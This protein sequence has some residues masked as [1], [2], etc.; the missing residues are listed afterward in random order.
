[1]CPPPGAMDLYRTHVKG[2]KFVEYRYDASGTAAYL[3][4]FE[5]IDK[6]RPFIRCE[7]FRILAQAGADS[8]FALGEGHVEGHVELLASKGSTG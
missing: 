5:S 8:P 7:I 1:M 4:G 3:D 2:R 6:A